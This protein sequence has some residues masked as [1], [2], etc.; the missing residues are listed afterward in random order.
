M[1]DKKEMVFICLKV[2]KDIK[3]KFLIA[4]KK[5][6]QSMTASLKM[7]MKGMGDGDIKMSLKPLN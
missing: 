6:G 3:D 5:N 1:N 2:E 7:F 4:A